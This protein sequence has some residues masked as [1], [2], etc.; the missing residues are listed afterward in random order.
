MPGIKGRSYQT[1]RAL[2]GLES[3][4]AV[5]MLL[6]EENNPNIIKACVPLSVVR[7]K[8]AAAKFNSEEVRGSMRFTQDSPMEPTKVEVN[9]FF[10]TN[11]YSYGIDV[12]P[13]IKRRKNEIR[14][15][16]NVKET[17]YNPFHT[18]PE[19]VP[20]PGRGTTDQYAVG[21][22]SGKYGNLDGKTKEVF[23]KYDFNLNLYGYFSPI[24]RAVVIYAP[25]GPAIACANIELMS[26][27]MTTAY[28]TFDVPLQGQFIFRQ[29]SDDCNGDTYIYIEVSKPPGGP[30]VSKTF[31]H[32]WHVH[33]K[34]VATSGML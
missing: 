2:P 3:L 30:G 31:N 16:P 20:P 1:V 12:L 7:P 13:M 25:E 34:S 22:L 26:A 11:A 33:D 19:E 24:G 29:P 28:S 10:G 9:L 18:D 14:K 8:T 5:Y 21:D 23:Q 27:N 32:P 15:C 17:I 6:Y 4:P